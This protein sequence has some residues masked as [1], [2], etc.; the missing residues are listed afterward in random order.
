MIPGV[1]LSLMRMR[2]DI[3]G[4]LNK[5]LGNITQAPLKPQEHLIILNTNLIPALYHQLGLT[6]TSKKYLKWL[7]RSIRAAVRSF[8]S[9]I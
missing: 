8:H 7:D 2:A 6:A 9:I 5:G 1:P 4:K 3:A